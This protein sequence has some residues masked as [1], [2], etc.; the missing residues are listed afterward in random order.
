[1]T[2][3]T[4]EA[5]VAA[6]PPP[7]AAVSC[8]GL[9][10]RF[11]R[12]WAF[13]RVDLEV[14]AGQRLLV[15]GANGSGKTT[16]LKVISTLLAPSLGQL[17][18][19]GID[20]AEDPAAARRRLH[21]L[22]HSLGLYEDLSGEDNLRVFGRLLGKDDLDVDPVLRQVGLE[23]RPDPI[24]A[25][26]AGMRKRLQLAALLVKGP[27]LTLLDEPFAAL[28]PL[29]C[30]AVEGLIAALPGAV[31]VASHQVVRASRLCERAILMDQGAVRWMGPAEQAVEAWRAL[32]GGDDLQGG[33]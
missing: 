10:R 26:S 13:S 32:H 2:A 20:P 28:D 14:P 4:S 17:R 19:C 22:S 27:E 33:G 30:A 15:M 18:V 21:L 12:R 1:M 5:P 31:I 16:L 8:V 11:G 7:A 3:D 24:R 29:G 9:A 6:L 25:Y 23:R